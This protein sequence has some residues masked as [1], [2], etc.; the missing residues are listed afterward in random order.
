MISVR[1]IVHETVS[2]I[3]EEMDKLIILYVGKN[4]YREDS[5]LTYGELPHSDSLLGDRPDK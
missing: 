4:V 2:G 1:Y 3:C 5:P